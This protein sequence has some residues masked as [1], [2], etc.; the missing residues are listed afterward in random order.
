MMHDKAVVLRGVSREGIWETARGKAG[1]FGGEASVGREG[2]I[3]ASEK[4]G[5]Q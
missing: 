4:A 3:L 2:P 1:D 5:C